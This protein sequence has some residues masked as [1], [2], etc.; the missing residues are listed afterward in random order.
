MKKYTPLQHT[1]ATL[2]LGIRKALFMHLI[3]LLEGSRLTIALHHVGKL[4]TPKLP[5][6]GCVLRLSVLC[7][8]PLGQAHVAVRGLLITCPDRIIRNRH[9]DKH[10]MQ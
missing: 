9:G 1:L 10:K 3:Y 4:G 5:G 2:E 7:P 8:R 6:C